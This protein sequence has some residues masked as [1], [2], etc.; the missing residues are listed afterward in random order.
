LKRPDRL[1]RDVKVV[2]AAVRYPPSP[3]GAETH[4][5]ALAEG[6]VHK[7]HDVVVHTSDLH[8][9]YPFVRRELPTLVNGV[10]VVRH[11]ARRLANAWTVMPT[12]PRALAAEE[13]DILHA[14]S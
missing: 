14:H 11:R 5:A 9:E 12:M 10:R 13:A 1:A 4:V 2:L 6:L 8:T 7:G 3:G